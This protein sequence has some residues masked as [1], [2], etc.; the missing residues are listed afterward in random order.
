MYRTDVG[1]DRAP[2]GG[3]MGLILRFRLDSSPRCLNYAYHGPLAG[4]NMHVLDRDLLYALA[5]MA[6][7]C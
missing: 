6:I 3:S 2:V 5:A 1:Q 7:E 4:G